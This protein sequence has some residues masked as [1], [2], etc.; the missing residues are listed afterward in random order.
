[1][2]DHSNYRAWTL[3]VVTMSGLALSSIPVTAQS[4]AGSH[5][6]V[7]RE[8]NPSVVD[9]QSEPRIVA[10][11]GGFPSLRGRDELAADRQGAADGSPAS[12]R[13]GALT[14]TAITMA[15]SLVVVLGLFAGLV[16]VTR[17]FGGAGQG[18]GELPKEVLT[19]L[20]GTAI[21]PRTRIQLIR[22]GSKILVVCQTAG[23]MTPLSEIADPDEVATVTA[24]CTGDSKKQ[25]LETLK[26]FEKQPVRLGFAEPPPA[27]PSAVATPS[28][29]PRGRLFT[30]A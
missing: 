29:R 3:A 25:F 19:P 13:R 9:D 10:K 16:W 4:P 8:P 12:T 17:R 30:T 24:A 7:A 20:G 23:G 21:D 28:P 2:P 11:S 15:T 14:G 27:E 22:C 6:A 1:V 26:S 18:G 5:Y